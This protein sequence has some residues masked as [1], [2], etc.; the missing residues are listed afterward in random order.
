MKRY[1]VKYR[2]NNTDSKTTLMLKGGGESEAIAKLKA[3]N[4]VPKDADVIIYFVNPA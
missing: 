3:Q 2:I 4:S 1:T